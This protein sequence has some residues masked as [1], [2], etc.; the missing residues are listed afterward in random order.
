[1]CV[2]CSRHCSC[3]GCENA[4][5][6]EAAKLREQSFKKR[7]A[8][9]DSKRSRIAASA[10]SNINIE[11]PRATTQETAP[12]TPT[13]ARA[14]APVLQAKQ[15]KTFVEPARDPLRFLAPGQVVAG[16]PPINGLAFFIT[17]SR[18]D[19]P[20][21]GD[22]NVE[23]QWC[24]DDGHR[25]S[26][27]QARDAALNG[28]KETIADTRHH[29]ISQSASAATSRAN[30]S[31]GSSNRML[32]SVEADLEHLTNVIQTA[33]LHAITQFRQVGEM[34]GKRTKRSAAEARLKDPNALQEETKE[35]RGMFCREELFPHDGQSNL[36]DTALQ[37][38]IVGAT[39]DTALLRE[40][41]RLI[42]E[43]TR[44][45]AQKRMKTHPNSALPW[46]SATGIRD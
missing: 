44:V 20:G 34:R 29:Q 8:M 35:E 32:Q 43:R 3:V 14:T 42:R 13:Q 30:A 25:P 9:A 21:T 40:A 31:D 37:E 38:L 17:E 26:L 18:R 6:P 4:A 22:E 11:P 33:K 2:P 36:D 39:Q 28:V 10:A 16:T 5:T 46:N 7:K 19:K 24:G 23:E 41:T 1:M 12:H 27:E 45:L 15:A